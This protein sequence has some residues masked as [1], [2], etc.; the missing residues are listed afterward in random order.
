MRSAEAAAVVTMKIFVTQYVVAEACIF[1]LEPRSAE[2]RAAA[3]LVAQ[4]DPAQTPRKLIRHLAEVLQPAGPDRTFVLEVVAVITVEPA[5]R[6]DDQEVNQHPDRA[7]PIG[8]AA[9][10]TRIRVSGHIADLEPVVGSIEHIGMF[11]IKF[12]QRANSKLG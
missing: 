6:F 1:L 3:L 10:H 2:H 4:K 11:P 5:Q 7:A 8:I 12:R 9:E